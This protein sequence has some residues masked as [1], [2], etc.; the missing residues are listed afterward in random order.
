MNFCTKSL[1]QFCYTSIPALFRR[2]NRKREQRERRAVKDQKRFLKKQA[3][4]E[5]H[6][7]KNQFTIEKYLKQIE[8]TLAKFHTYALGKCNLSALDLTQN[9]LGELNKNK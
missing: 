1:I 3:I 9:V 6:L 8:T 2:Y 7:A 4:I 5:L